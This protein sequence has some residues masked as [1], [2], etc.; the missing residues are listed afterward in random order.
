[1]KR[2]AASVQTKR[3]AKAASRSRR[4]GRRTESAS[5]TWI[6][7]LASPYLKGYR[8]VAANEA[9][10]QGYWFLADAPSV[11]TRKNS[12]QTS[13][14]NAS[15]K[16]GVGFF[17]GYITDATAEYSFLKPAPPECVIFAFVAPIDGPLHNELVKQQGSLVRKTFEYI[18]WLTHRPPRFVFHEAEVAAMARHASMADWPPEKRQHLSR[19]FFI[20]TLA[21]LVRSGLVRKLKEEA[22]SSEGDRT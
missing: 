22:G 18:R 10:L 14:R 4:D 19:N 13:S 5:A 16:Y 6:R 17:V 15:P 12:D 7:D 2:V 3:K 11:L 1:M 8:P 20:E 21:W 9:S